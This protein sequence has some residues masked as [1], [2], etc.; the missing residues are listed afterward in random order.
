[1]RGLGMKPVLPGFYGMVPRILKEKYPDADI[2]D[3]GLWAGGFIRPA[4]LSPNDSLFQTI[5]KIY[6]E[7][8]NKL[9]GDIEFFSGDPFHEGGITE[10]IDLPSAGENI[11]SG[12][13]EVFPA[14]TWV[15]QGWGENPK[16]P[17]LSKIN[18]SDLL[19]LDLDGDNDPQWEDRNGWEGKP[20]IWNTVTNFGGNVGMFGRMDVIAREPFRALAHPEYSKALKGIGAMPEGIE[21]NS[22][23]YELLFDVKWH[24]EAINPDQWLSEYIKRRYEKEDSDLYTAWQILRTT[25]YGKK[26]ITTESQQGTSESILC[27]RPSLK[28]DRVS[29]WG[30]SKLNYEPSELLKAWTLFIN[31]AE[32][33][34]DVEGFQYDLVN[35]TRQVL[36]N[37]AQVV[38]AKIATAYERND[39]EGF[40]KAINEFL[41]LLDDQDL[42]LSSIDHFM[43]GKWIEEAR[44]AATTQAE[45]DLFEFNARTLI[46]TWSFQN[47][48]L[49]DYAH[50]EW[51]GLLSDFYKPRWEMFFDYL[52]KNMDGIKT[53]EPDYYAFEAAWTK[54]TNSFPSKAILD[55]VKQAQLIYEG[56]YNKIE[57]GY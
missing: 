41:Q 47:S 50:R 2:R 33:Y 29:S 53:P 35:I 37:Y 24:T 21:N 51:S 7:E 5:A 4:F 12:M 11:V 56:Y 19:I 26:L 48:N 18:T 44:R 49:H 23:I 20:W 22:V 55:P 6:Y 43:L 1:M 13:K 14:S 30:T 27:A 57:S 38:H 15:F 28:I 9:Y 52:K 31:A 32:N 40:G 46:T 17:L 39:K 16:A 25:V 34:K 3:Q 10:G 8:M 42:L 45:K 36:A 54:Q